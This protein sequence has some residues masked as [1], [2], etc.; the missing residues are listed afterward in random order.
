LALLH[1][2]VLAGCSIWK[3][4]GQFKTFTWLWRRHLGLY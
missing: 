4:Q 2:K 3:I 1:L